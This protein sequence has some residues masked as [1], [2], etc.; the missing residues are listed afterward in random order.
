[1]N[2]TKCQMP[3]RFNFK[4]KCCGIVILVKKMSQEVKYNGFVTN[5]ACT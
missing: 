4:T 3:I 1:M 5:L 2:S